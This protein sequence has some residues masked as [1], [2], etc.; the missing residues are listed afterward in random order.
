MSHDTG[1]PPHK[2]R[3]MLTVDESGFVD[4]GAKSNVNTR[5]IEDVASA[6]RLIETVMTRAPTIP[7]VVGEVVYERVRQVTARAI[8][9][10]NYA[11]FVTTVDRVPCLYTGGFI[12]QE[13][14]NYNKIGNL[15]LIIAPLNCHGKQRIRST[16][17][18][19]LNV[20]TC[21]AF[22]KGVK[23]VILGHDSM[24]N[25]SDVIGKLM[26]RWGYTRVGEVYMMEVA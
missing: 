18:D 19:A 8:S 24:M 10:P 2:Q 9:D 23:R 12:S 5:R 14:H 25:H 16:L 22:A 21:W 6:A 13:L 1:H 3:R 17:H 11:M 4:M 20:F 15:T 26:S 7:N